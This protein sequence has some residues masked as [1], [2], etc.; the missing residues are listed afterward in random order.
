MLYNSDQ[1]PLTKVQTT[2][3]TN[4]L[5]E[6]ATNEVYTFRGEP[7]YRTFE[8]IAK[9]GGEQGFALLEAIFVKQSEICDK[10]STNLTVDEAGKKK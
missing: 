7:V 5:L 2:I 4:T 1:V 10:S 3:L 6:Y 9:R 8:A